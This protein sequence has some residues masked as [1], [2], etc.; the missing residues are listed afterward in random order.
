[1]AGDVGRSEMVDAEE[2]TVDLVCLSV[3]W[4]LGI[5]VSLGLRYVQAT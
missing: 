2:A 3:D 5:L 1:M 4:W